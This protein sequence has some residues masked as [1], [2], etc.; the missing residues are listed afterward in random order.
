MNDDITGSGGIGNPFAEAEEGA[1]RLLGTV[2]KLNKQRITPK[3]ET[4]QLDIANKKLKE[5]RQIVKE[6]KKPQQYTGKDI[7]GNFDKILKSSNVS[8]YISD[9][10]KQ[11]DEAVDYI[12]GGNGRIE[13][14]FFKRF[15]NNYKRL[16]T[17]ASMAKQSG[18]DLG[19]NLNLDKYWESIGKALSQGDRLEGS[20][21]YFKETYVD[22]NNVTE[23]SKELNKSL[24]NEVIKEFANGLTL[25]KRSDAQKA[26]EETNAEV[27]ELRDNVQAL[28][29]ENRSKKNDLFE[30]MQEHLGNLLSMMGKVQ[31]EMGDSDV[32]D[33]DEN[34]FARIQKMIFDL[35][36][37]MKEVG[38]ETKPIEDMFEVL[39]RGQYMDQGVV[40]GFKATREEVERL[41]RELEELRENYGYLENVSRQYFNENLDLKVQ[42]EEQNKYQ[43]ELKE[44]RDEFEKTGEAFKSGFGGGSGDGLG[45]GV[46]HLDD[47]LEKIENHLKEI[48]IALG[49]VD[50]NSG[51]QSLIHSLDILLGKL[52]EIQGKVGQ[53]IFNVNISQESDDTLARKQKI[54]AIWRDTEQRYQNGYKKIMEI[55]EKMGYSVQ[56]TMMK[57][58][59]ATTEL[60]M[61]MSSD[62]FLGLFSKSSISSIDDAEKRVK[63]LI[64]FFEIVKKIKSDPYLKNED[65]FY[66]KLSKKGMPSTSLTTTKRK[67]KEVMP[68]EEE[69]KAV[70][71]MVAEAMKDAEE[72][73]DKVKVDLREVTNMLEEIADILVGISEKG[74][75]GDEFTKAISQ[76]TELVT[77]MGILDQTADSIGLDKMTISTEQSERATR[78]WVEGLDK[79]QS[80]AKETA[81]AFEKIYQA[82]READGGYGLD[83]LPTTTTA[84]LEKLATAEK[85]LVDTQEK[86]NSVKKE[87]QASPA[88]M[89]EISDLEKLQSALNDVIDWIN[90]KTKAFKEEEATV[91]N[92]VANEVVN[93]EEL[94]EPL[95]KISGS[96]SK[97]S[98][99]KGNKSLGGLVTNI[100]K[101][102]ESLDKFNMDS[103]AK[104][105]EQ[106]ATSFKTF[107]ESLSNVN[108]DNSMI[109]SINE[110]IKNASKLEKAT[111]ALENYNKASKT[112][113]KEKTKKQ[114]T[115]EKTPKT[116]EELEEKKQALLSKA[117]GSL[118]SV[119]AK[120][121]HFLGGKEIADEFRRIIEEISKL[122]TASKGAEESLKKLKQDL[123]D[124][125][126][127]ASKTFGD[128]NKGF[129]DSS[130]ITGEMAKLSQFMQKNSGASKEWKNNLENCYAVL[131]KLSKEGRVTNEEFE[132]VKTSI[133]QTEAEMRRAGETGVSMWD[134]MKRS[135]KSQI[136]QQ[137]AMYLSLQDFIRYFRTA[138]NT[139][140]ELDY[141]LVDLRKTTT[142]SANDLNQFYK[143]ANESAK[144][145]GVTTKEIIEQAAQWSRLNKI[146]PL[147]SNI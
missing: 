122:D 8:K 45:G 113:E 75:F 131:E 68:S 77:K 73:A 3:V 10:K 132:A 92:V 52:D 79:V 27:K 139:I 135:L 40:G 136:A 99:I 70:T 44:T 30:E 90:L 18:L 47:L 22:I 98:E 125:G 4:K 85:E 118:A 83:F 87:Q 111:K 16:E 88:I 119:E 109:N 43:G 13:E 29:N 51:F 5:Q 78:E 9:I 35:V 41:T 74:I 108:I 12:N 133:R 1:E 86:L 82:Q 23:A 50:E 14:V 61:G 56:D 116:P 71:D 94:V 15:T 105:F 101:L 11:M 53:G 110:L 124:A 146:G 128:R 93:L 143:D 129:V 138:F 120:E 126:Q 7:F 107:T 66:E 117:K 62:D 95:E 72:N 65:P 142:M 89:A 34:S 60:G 144:Q 96:L 121:P 58:Y 80:E 76:L 69:E 112:A 31:S 64:D 103:I 39:S 55:G 100:G 33:V 81:D 97:F 26:F 123:K 54:D 147:Y 57:I 17:I 134:R 127:A 104:S 140:R 21:R 2:E 145:Y 84:D 28:K 137:A 19:K 37:A 106:F 114:A 59:S 115:K 67:L 63:R 42:L 36:N 102:L 32:W 38:A 48:R 24:R 91:N 141:A 20:A 46:G 25:L 6:L 130:A 49:S